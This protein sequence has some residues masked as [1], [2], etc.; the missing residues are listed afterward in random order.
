ML[1]GAALAASVEAL[2][3]YGPT[4]KAMAVALEASRHVVASFTDLNGTVNCREIIGYDLSSAVGMV[5]FMFKTLSKGLKN[6]QCFDMAEAW[7]P[8]AVDTVSKGTVVPQ[9]AFQMPVVNCASEVAKHMGASPEEAVMV[10]GF[11]GGLGL[12]GHG[13]GALSAAIWKKSLDFCKEHPGKSPPIFRNKEVRNMIK[14]FRNVT[15]SEM[16]CS[17]ICGRKF[18]SVDEHSEYIRRGGCREII[19]QLSS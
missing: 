17:A 7:A 8:M 5:G 4:D 15:G 18:D 9:E 10:A 3:R 6:S 12:S 11:A 19:Q 13:C 14:A 1:W 2:R 16:K